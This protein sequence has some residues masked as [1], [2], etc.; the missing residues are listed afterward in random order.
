MRL[1][2]GPPSPACGGLKRFVANSYARLFE[3]FH[4]FAGCPQPV[5]EMSALARIESGQA[6]PLP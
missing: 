3:V 2:A 6:F 5:T 4:S 1:I